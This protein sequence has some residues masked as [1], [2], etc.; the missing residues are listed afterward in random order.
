MTPVDADGR[1]VQLA[2]NIDRSPLLDFWSSGYRRYALYTITDRAIP[3]AFDG[4]KPGQRRLLVTMYRQGLLPGTKFRKSAA[5]ASATTAALHPHGDAAMYLS[6]AGLAAAYQRVR[7]IEGQGAYPRVTGETPASER[8]TEMRLARPGHEVVRDIDSDT[9]DM[10]PSYDGETTEPLVLPLRYPL[11]LING[12]DTAIAVAYSAKIPAHNP[13]EVIALTRALI[14]DPDLSD[15]ELLRLL[16][17]PDWNVDTIVVGTSGIRDYM[18][19]GRGKMHLRGRVEVTD[20]K[21]ITVHSLPPGVSAE[22]FRT[23]VVKGTTRNDQGVIRLPGVRDLANLSDRRRPVCIEITVKQGHDAQEV[24]TSLLMYTPLEVT[25]SASM[26]AGDLDRIPRWWTVREFVSAF[27]FLRDSVVVRRSEFRLTKAR[28]RQHLVAGLLA[29]LAD[30]DTAVSIIRSSETEEAASAA[31]QARFGIDQVQADR[32]LEMK[33]RSLT[34]QDTLKLQAEYQRLAATISEMQ[35]LISDPQ[36]RMRQIDTELADTAHMFDGPE[37]DRRT[38]IDAEA[39]PTAR[40][41][42]GTSAAVPVMSDKWCLSEHGMFGTDGV[43]LTE[44]RAWAAY[45]D[46]RIKITDGKGLRGDPRR[47]VPVSPNLDGLLVCGVA[48]EGT[49]LLLVTAR[50]QGLRV[51]PH[52]INTQGVAGNGIAGIKLGA[53]VEAAEAT[54]D[55]PEVLAREADTVVA[56]VALTGAAGEAVLLRTTAGFKVLTADDIPVKGRGGQGVRLFAEAKGFETEQV[57][58]AAVSATGFAEGGKKVRMSKRAVITTKRADA[59]LTSL[60]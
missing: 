32:V 55:Q 41:V 3:S 57:I 21:T 24:L 15:D 58:A 47:S 30:L 59:D 7:L 44:G 16:P 26:V 12:A 13:R 8:Y 36:A 25:Y 35:E 2:A 19:T 31:L 29:I 50:G 22:T 49:D 5:V 40:A 52:A 38:V 9:V 53:A 51:T 11:M 60:S 17:G 20:K 1:P 28:T 6:A 27:L 54:E 34:S 10:V 33:L 18:L 14:A 23:A 43:L 56:A 48:P 45:T 39:V 4:L 42:E 46:G 37:Y